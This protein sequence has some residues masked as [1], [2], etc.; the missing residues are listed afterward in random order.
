M[1]LCVSQKHYYCLYSF[2]TALLRCNSQVTSAFQ[3]FTGYHLLWKNYISYHFRSPKETQRG[4]LLLCKRQKSKN[5]TQHSICS[6]PIQRQC[7]APPPP[8]TPPPTILGISVSVCHRF[9]LSLRASVLYLDWFC[10]F[11]SK[12]CPKIILLCLL[13]FWFMKGFTETL[14]LR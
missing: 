6:K 4:F 1:F 13:P 10:V 8:T 12:M 2:I 7:Q 3:K 5:S 14:Y 11:I 9:E